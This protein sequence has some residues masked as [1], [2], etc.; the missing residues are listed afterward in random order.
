MAWPF[1][2][3]MVEIDEYRVENYDDNDAI[4][5]GDRQHIMTIVTTVGNKR[6]KYK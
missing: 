3:V 1:D 2:V 4:M 6:R 5:A